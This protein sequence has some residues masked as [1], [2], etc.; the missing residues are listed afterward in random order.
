[1][2]TFHGNEWKKRL[3]EPDEVIKRLAPGMTIFIGTGVSEP[4]TLFRHL[5]ES[6][7]ANIDLEV[8]QLVS[9]GHAI[10]V[11]EN[12]SSIYRL[13]TF[14]SGWDADEAITKGLAD[15]IP[16][17]YRQIPELFRSKQITVD[18]VFIQITPPNEAGFCSL[19]VCVDVGRLAMQQASFVV[20]EINPWM[21]RTFGDTFVHISDFDLLV[22]AQEPPIYF[23]RWKFDAVYD[24]IAENVSSMIEDQSCIGFSIGP[25][26]EALSKHLVHKKD[27]GIHTPF[28]FDNMMDLVKSGAVTNQYKINYQGKSLTSYAIG[29]PELMAWLDNNPL[30]E[31]QSVDKVFNP[32]HISANPKF[33][34]VLAARKVDLYGRIALHTGRGNVGSGPGEVV[35]F[36]NGALLS[37]GGAAIFALPSRNRQ[38]ESNIVLS[39]VQYPNQFSLWESVSTIVTEYGIADVRGRTVRERAQAL[40][41]IAHPD[42]RPKLVEDARNQRIIYPDQIYIKESAH[43]YPSGIKTKKTFS[44]GLEVCFRAIKP[45]DEEN[46]RRLFYRFSD[47]SV[48]YRYFSRIKAMPHATMQEYVNIDYKKTLSIVAELKNGKLIAEARF[49]S[50]EIHETHPEIAIVVD[51]HY[52]NSGIAT[53]IL[54]MLMQQAKKRKLKGFKGDILPDNKKIINVLKKIDWKLKVNLAK[55]SIIIDF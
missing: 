5:K 6:H 43:L 28:F 9:L 36:F 48:Y 33:T 31:F 53:Y 40:I 19:G 26:Y 42:D 32:V 35:D 51:E 8:F 13:K 44:N 21:P 11:Q 27:L 23:E 46:M 50:L 41:D 54:T 17:R 45:S 1:M 29:T 12:H 10:S 2:K 37:E 25:L 30:L 38:G 3:V 39:A 14:F 55:D 15:F 24:K 47:E 34:A 18:A 22:E 16:S 20:G 49:A 52:Q 4:L 7:Y